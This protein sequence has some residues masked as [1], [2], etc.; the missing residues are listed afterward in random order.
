MKA[1]SQ[2]ETMGQRESKDRRR[3]LAASVTLFAGAAISHDGG[4][5]DAG[6]PVCLEANYMVANNP[7]GT[8]G[9]GTV[10]H[11]LGIQIMPNGNLV[12][13]ICEAN[14]FASLEKY[15]GSFRYRQ[16]PQR[17]I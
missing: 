4:D 5:N 11:P 9:R 14:I 10:P 13:A 17:M 2:G 7:T 1:K 12:Q 3:L 6:T 15:V 8:P 16:S